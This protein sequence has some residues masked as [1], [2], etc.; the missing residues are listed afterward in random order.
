MIMAY[1]STQSVFAIGLSYLAW[2]TWVWSSSHLLKA[3]QIIV[4]HVKR[5][6]WDCKLIQ[7]A[8][9]VEETVNIQEEGL[10]IIL[11]FFETL[12]LAELI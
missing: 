7:T 8:E 2:K 6:A 3:K 12:V 9:S 4:S 1:A 11:P 10:Q 5:P